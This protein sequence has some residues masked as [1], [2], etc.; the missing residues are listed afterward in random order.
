MVYE[1]NDEAPVGTHAVRASALRV[2]LL[3]PFE[4]HVGDR[5]ILP[6]AWSG[7]AARSLFLLLLGTPGNRLHRDQ[8]IDLLWPEASQESALNGLYKALHALRRVLEPTLQTG[9]SSAHIDVAQDQ[10]AIRVGPETWID[11]DFFERRLGE[12]SAMFPSERRSILRGALEL[13]RGD[14]LSTELYTDWPIPRR[15]HLRR[16]RDAAALELA[17][18][19]LE[20]GESLAS[21]SQVEQILLADPT[22]EEAH[23][24]LM[25][26]YAA[27][28][29]R[30]RALKQ[31]DACRQALLEDLHSD[32]TPET[33]ALLEII[34]NAETP[35]LGRSSDYQDPL[36]PRFRTPA[37]PTPTVGRTREIER[38]QSLLSQEHLRLVT[39]TG[40]GGIGK[41][42]VAI[43][44][45]SGMNDQF[46]GGIEFVSMA[47]INEAGMVMPA[48]GQTLQ[49]REDHAR[50]ID[51]VIAAYLGDRSFLLVV[52]NFE[53]V[54]TAA[55][56]IA[57][58]LAECHGLKILATSRE[59]LRIRGEYEFRLDPLSLPR[60]TAN[61]SL[62]ILRRSESVALF[63]QTLETHRPD[64]ELSSSAI[65]AIANLCV[66]LEGLPLAIEL[67]ASRSRHLSPERLLDQLGH[68]MAVLIDGP[69]DLPDRQRTIRDAIGWSYNLLSEQ[70]RF[71]FCQL[72]V[73]AGGATLDAIRNLWGDDAELIVYALADKSLLGWAAT[74]RSPRVVMLETIRAYG[75]EQL[76]LQ[77]ALEQARKTHARYF[78]TIADAALPNYHGPDGVHVLNR[79]E[80]DHDNFRAAL[81]WTISRNDAGSSLQMAYALWR[82]WWM[83]GHLSEGRTWLERSLGVPGEV[84]ASMRSKSLAATG[85]FARVQ[86]DLDHAQKLGVEGLAIARAEE[87]LH[88]MM[89]NLHL[90]SLVAF[91]SGNY[92]TARQLIEEA[93]FIDRLPVRKNAHGIAISLQ[94][95]GDV[96]LAQRRFDLAS[97]RY[98][99]SLAIWQERDD[100]WGM[101]RAMFGLGTVAVGQGNLVSASKILTE[102]LRLSLEIGDSEQVAEALT[103]L[104]AI[105]A[106]V[107]SYQA[108]Q[109]FSAAESLHAS[110]STPIAT[111]NRERHDSARTDAKSRLNHVDFERA[112]NDGR[113][114]RASAMLEAA[115][116]I[117]AS[118][119]S[120]Q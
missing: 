53:H 92:E 32:P 120:G 110:L 95:L 48:I 89:G 98:R 16:L 28:G 2:R 70:E 76:E 46:P 96:E 3:G 35:T 72:S 114:M 74:D 8:V 30:D 4:A 90:L 24:A 18:L 34:Q 39:L 75:I 51:D 109:L 31:F 13:Y 66:Q 17:A 79:L 115:I 77:G 78:L 25:R 84:P 81:N 20:A 68:V 97:D 36:A 10:I 54:I 60:M 9:K 5:A 44:A 57:R 43:A 82:L 102:S 27:A 12:A 106:P 69:R 50:S 94:T 117:A 22:I 33:I 118:F 14:F 23:R 52:D 116:V 86:G 59:P 65:Q 107:C 99:E 29:Q 38:V 61:P 45:A 87:D 1:V 101:A 108:V 55:V 42:R 56:D 37:L 26:A 11:V 47:S 62:E 21:I 104:A 112:S 15:A 83:R 67:A 7:R 100:R 49:L 113:N 64:I 93:L 6:G 105:A 40:P 85:Y 19:D 80:D 41:T 103:E 63:L 73:F 111:I 119:D 58:L 91:D 71:V 88:C